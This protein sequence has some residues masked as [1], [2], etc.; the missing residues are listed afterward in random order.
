[1]TSCE[2]AESK[3]STNVGPCTVIADDFR[4]VLAETG[5]EVLLPKVGHELNSSALHYV[6]AKMY[7]AVEVV[8]VDGFG[9]MVS[10]FVHCV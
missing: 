1:M 3:S 10:F 4:V 9:L 2:F 5:I 8:E 7:H 6:L